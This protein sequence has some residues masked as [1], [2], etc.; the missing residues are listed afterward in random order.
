MQFQTLGQTQDLF[1]G[2]TYHGIGFAYLSKLVEVI[3]LFHKLESQNFVCELVKKC[4][5][6]ATADESRQHAQLVGL[7]VDSHSRG[8]YR[9]IYICGGSVKNFYPHM[10]VHIDH[11]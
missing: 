1:I 7:A 6:I 9:Y 4:R 3:I 11:S 10:R 2:N 8:S 5:F